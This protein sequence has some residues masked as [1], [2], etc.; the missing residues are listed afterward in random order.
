MSSSATTSAN[1]GSGS[2]SGELSTH[3]ALLASILSYLSSLKRS[4]HSTSLLLSLDS[5][6]AALDCLSEATGL[7]LPPPVD[8]AQPSQ[9]TPPPPSLVDVYI[10]GVA[11]LSSSA[12]LSSAASSASSAAPFS[13][14]VSLLTERGF[15][16][17]LQPGSAAYAERLTAARAKYDEKYPD[18]S[19]AS[20][21][22]STLTAPSASSGSVS[23]SDAQQAEQLKA[24]GNAYLS[25]QQ[26]ELAVARYSAAIALNPHSA[27][28][29]GN[30]AAAHINLSAWSEAESDCRAA[31]AIDAKYG[32]GGR[33]HTQSIN[34]SLRQHRRQR[35]V[36]AARSLS[37]VS[38]LPSRRQPTTG[39]VRV[40][41]R[42]PVLARLCLRSSPLCRPLTRACAPL[43]TSSWQRHGGRLSATTT[44]TTAARRS[45]QRMRAPTRTAEGWPG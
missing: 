6:D 4:P 45:S 21:G 14:F 28:Y 16:A 13:Q 12:S 25:S 44:A 9:P 38:L 26:Y 24:E 17:S 34:Q 15:F 23:A 1:S 5:L 20:G 8:A 30:R 19:S 3:R 10:A 43:S 41:C 27:I 36:P 42:R 39:W 7:P 32:K 37:A 35:S 33:A 29:F 31:I 11:A 40:C 22:S 18:R 2:G